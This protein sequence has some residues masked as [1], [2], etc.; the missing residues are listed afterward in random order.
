LDWFVPLALIITI[1]A[2]AVILYVFAF[3]SSRNKIRCPLCESESVEKIP[4]QWVTSPGDGFNE[5]PVTLT[6]HY[7]YKCRTCQNE[8]EDY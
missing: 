8:W 4:K 1:L 5:T 3:F 2:I 6:S 7:K